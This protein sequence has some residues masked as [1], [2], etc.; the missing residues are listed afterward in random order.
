MMVSGH[1]TRSIIERYNIVSQSDLSDASRSLQAHQT[2]LAG[3]ESPVMGANHD[4]F[5]TFDDWDY[6]PGER[7]SEASH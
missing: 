3:G 6:I 2:G 5:T 7:N 4:I 1:K